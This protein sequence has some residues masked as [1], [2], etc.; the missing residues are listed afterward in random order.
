M[1][2]EHSSFYRKTDVCFINS[3]TWNSGASIH[4]ISKKDLKDAEMDT[5][6]KPC[7]PTIVITVNG[8]VQTHGK[9]T[10]YVTDLDIFLTFKILENTSAVLSLVTMK[11]GILMHGSMVKNNIAWK[12]DSENV[13][14]GELRVKFVFWIWLINFDDTFKTGKSLLN[15]FFNLIFSI[16]CKWNSD[17]KK[18]NRTENDISLMK[19][20]GDPKLTKPKRSPRRDKAN[21]C[22]LRSRIGGKNSGKF[23]WMMKFHYM[24]TLTSV[25]LTNHL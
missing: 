10:V 14:H 13:Q 3:Y 11:T 6:P 1:K 23:W 12:K 18:R 2:K 8:D 24:E 22:V 21:R 25:S 20:Q 19:D 17:S 5:L 16:Y 9:T 4:M 15:T 7:S